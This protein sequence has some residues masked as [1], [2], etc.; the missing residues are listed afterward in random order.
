MNEDKKT[1]KA[2]A[3]QL[4]TD[5]FLAGTIEMSQEEVGQFIRL[6]CHQWNR[7]SI[8]VETEKQ[9]RLAGG[10]V[11]VDVLAKFDHCDDGLLRNKR[12]E[13]VRTE[14]GKFLQ[15]Q[16]AKGKLSA[17]KR[18]LEA[19]ERKSESNQNSTAVEPVL[20]PDDQPDT[21][22][23]SNS[24]SPSP[25]PN[26][27]DTASPK[28]PWDVGFGVEL[29]N[30]F[31]TENCLQAVKLWLQYKSERKEGYKKT[32]LTASLTKWSN[33]FS[34]AEFPSAV[35]N[36]I[37]SGWKGIFPTGKQQQQPQAKSVNLSLNIADY[38]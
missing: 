33:E 11:S 19:L 13:S 1:R 28:S 38:Q 23:K 34:P 35:E 21:Q 26:K 31:Q 10:C 8:P 27:K 6:L 15:S 25:T 2:P 12:L 4:Y 7:G 5:D 16:S 20:Q 24:P 36:S 9:Q 3:F 30:S 37:A 32:G 29:P 14:K 18:R 17:E 22:P